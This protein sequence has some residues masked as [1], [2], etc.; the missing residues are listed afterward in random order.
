[1]TTSVFEAIEENRVHLAG[2]GVGVFVRDS[3]LRELKTPPQFWFGPVLV[4][5]ILDGDSP[6]LSD[7]EVRAANS[8][9]GLNQLVWEALA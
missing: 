2:V 9:E 6:V 8:G 7:Q 5:R 1:M 4:Q 3:F